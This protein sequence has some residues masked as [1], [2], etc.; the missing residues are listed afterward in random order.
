MVVVVAE[1]VVAVAAVTAAERPKE[2]LTTLLNDPS[3]T[4]SARVEAI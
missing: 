4:L 1:E 3:P 2:S